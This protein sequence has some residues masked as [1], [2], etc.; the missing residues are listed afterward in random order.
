MDEQL[1]CLQS[2]AAYS[3]LL[4]TLLRESFIPSSK[5]MKDDQLGYVNDKA[6]IT[7]MQEHVKIKS[8]IG[9]C[10][11]QYCSSAKEL[12]RKM[13]LD[14]VKKVPHSHKAVQREYRRYLTSRV[15]RNIEDCLVQHCCECIEP[16]LK[17]Q[18]S[19]LEIEC[20]YNSARKECKLLDRAVMR[21]AQ[22]PSVKTMFELYKQLGIDIFLV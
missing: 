14:F 16:L 5:K 20:K 17:N 13:Y 4:S 3:L 9:Q 8:S 21:L 11:K 7:A 18:I 10:V 15:H 1:S 19:L 22:K 2:V 12:D 6:W